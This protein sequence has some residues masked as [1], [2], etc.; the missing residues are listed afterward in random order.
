MDNI[1]WLVIVGAVVV[2]GFSVILLQKKAGEAKNYLDELQKIRNKL[3]EKNDASS[4]TQIQSDSK[5]QE[6]TSKARKLEEELEKLK[7]ELAERTTEAERLST[8][9]ASSTDSQSTIEDLTQ[10]LQTAEDERDQ[11]TSAI[12][13]MEKR[14]EEVV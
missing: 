3:N 8:E 4:K 13:E 11:K 12:T 9:L 6:A 7:S 10:R 1:I 5:F 14:S 2:A